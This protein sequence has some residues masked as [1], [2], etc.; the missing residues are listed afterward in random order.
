MAKL[1]MQYCI[2]YLMLTI[3]EGNAPCSLTLIL[4]FQLLC[5]D[6]DYGNISV[7]NKQ[8]KI[9]VSEVQIIIIA[10]IFH[11]HVIPLAYLIL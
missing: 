1:V 4:V 10:K 2:K 7:S 3:A 8:E 5:S 6:D 9:I 11:I